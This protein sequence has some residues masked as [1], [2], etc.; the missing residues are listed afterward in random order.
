MAT[1]IK[2]ISALLISILLFAGI[3][4][5]LDFES[6]DFESDWSDRLLEYVQTRFYNPSVLNSFL[7]E[8]TIDAGLAENHILELQ[9]RF[10]LTLSEEAVRRSFLY[11]QRPED[12]F[13][14]SR[15]FG[16]LLE[17]TGGLQT[18]QFVDGNGIR[19]HYST[20]PRD[21]INRTSSS[22]SYRNYNED[23]LALPYETVSVPAGSGAKF[24]MDEQT[25]RIIFSYP[26]HDSMDVYR[27]T[28]IFSVSV[29]SVADRFI[30]EGRLKINEDISVISAPAG[31]LLGS[32]HVI[33]MGSSRKNIL[34]KVS[35]VWIGGLNERSAYSSIPYSRVTIETEET[36]VK[37]SLIS[38]KIR[39]LYF[40]RLIDDYILSIPESM[41]LLFKLAVFLTFFL[42]LFFLLNFKPNAVTLVRNRIKRLRDSL[43]EHLYINK[44]PGERAKWIIELEQRRE[45]I[46]AE[47]KRGLLIGARKKKI[48]D[49]EIDKS[50][51]ELLNVLK[52]GS[53][54]ITITKTAPEPVTA[55]K[56]TGVKGAEKTEAPDEIESLDEI[57]EAEPL[58][59]AEL[60]DEIDEA[61]PL[62]EIEEAES[63]DEIE[64]IEEIEEITAGKSSAPE[65]S[66]LHELEN[67]IDKA[68]SV[69]EKPAGLAARGLLRLAERKRTKKKGLLKLAEEKSNRKKGL[70]KLAEE[71]ERKKR[72]LLARASR[73]E[74]KEN[75]FAP[76]ADDAQDDDNND[77]DLPKI[78]IV[79][80]FSSMF[81]KLE[82]ED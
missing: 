77:N 79:S 52:S 4:W 15:I 76:S 40:G 50:W 51:D 43:F 39:D 54:P 2:T 59:E 10:A 56:Q 16:I 14:R 20:S 58:D 41:K 65:W 67:I 60:L 49:A 69:D 80:P 75:L 9:K 62:D 13:E 33:S 66:D 68:I 63:L 32:P 64:E 53:S 82:D 5:F 81:S 7:K 19:I 24:T 25:D 38:L 44:T 73:V 8:N 18:V 30:T 55:K 21:I 72:G 47:I 1:F 26:F 78:D 36:G 12:I 22:M 17:T 48:I 61:E 27:G 37:F 35:A 70:L 23:P 6:D 31:I 3:T 29:R 71:K 28:A 74:K 46:K 42:T 57:E 34:E 11:N 45:E